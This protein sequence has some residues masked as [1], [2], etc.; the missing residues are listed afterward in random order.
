MG[1]ILQESPVRSAPCE[2]TPKMSDWL[3][4]ATLRDLQ[5]IKIGILAYFLITHPLTAQF[6]DIENRDVSFIRRTVTS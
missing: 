4:K 1:R 3:N 6:L 2:A 5:I